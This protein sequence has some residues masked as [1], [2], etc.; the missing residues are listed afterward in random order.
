[1]TWIAATLGPR[2]FLL[3]SYEDAQAGPSAK[4]V[5]VTGEMATPEEARAAAER[6]ATTVRLSGVQTTPLSPEWITFLGLP[7]APPWLVH[8]RQPSA[9][10]HPWRSDPALQGSF[11]AQERDDIEATFVLIK[12]KALE[13]MW[14]RIEGVMPGIGYAGTLLNTANAAPELA[15]GT[16]VL[17]RP[18]KSHPPLMWV[19]PAAAA[20]LAKWSTVCE[21]CGFD[22]IFIPV[23]DL[24]KMTFPNMPPGAIME[25]FT[26]RCF[27][28]KATMHVVRSGG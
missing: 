8:F 12:E 17:V 13:K 27:M 18:S 25:R 21:A 4:G 20:N 14:V 9:E 5:E 7:A 24:A 23:E 6:P 11:H 2:R 3:F 19:P 1:M 15:R 10:T 22:L 16:K 28:C 26:T